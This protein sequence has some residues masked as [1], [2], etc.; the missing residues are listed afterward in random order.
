MHTRQ[1]L[2]LLLVAAV[3]AAGLVGFVA[4][5][6]SAAAADWTTVWRDDFDGPQGQLPS[7]DNWRFDLGT[8]YG[9]GEIETTTNDPAN[10]SLTGNSE[11]AITPLRDGNGA[12]TSGRLESNRD[13]FQPPAGGV[14]RLESRIQLPDVTG[15]AAAGYWPA[16]WSL[17]QPLRTGGQWPGVGE[18]DVLEDVNG[19]NLAYGTLHCGVS[20]GGPCNEGTGRGGSTACPNSQCPGNF[21][22]YAI[23]WDRSVSPEQIRWY[24]DDQQYF[25]V[26]A[27]Q[28]DAQTWQNAT[29]HGIYVLLD[30]AMGGA[31]PNGVA[32]GATPTAAT[33]PG[34]PMLIDY[35]S[36]ETR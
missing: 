36:V 13:D 11:L 19:Q 4:T 7:S 9:T 24:V 17:G 5:G 8:D 2:R 16:F 34:H 1:L 21:H 6:P 18:I 26:D 28:F 32:G 3:A 27:S 30:L 22:T 31:F 33:E 20:P 10:V 14:L 23:E 12:W 25:A 35:V 29:G 15:A